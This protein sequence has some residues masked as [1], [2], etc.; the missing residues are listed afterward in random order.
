MMTAVKQTKRVKEC[1]RQGMQTIIIY[2]F[3]T[4][5]ALQRQDLTSQDVENVK[6]IVERGGTWW[7]VVEQ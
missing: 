2:T 5:V 7:N 4:T 6:T 3:T 1:Q